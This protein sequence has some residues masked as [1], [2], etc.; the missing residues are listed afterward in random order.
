MHPHVENPLFERLDGNVVLFYQ[1]DADIP[2][3]RHID[4][5]LVFYVKRRKQIQ[6]AFF[7]R[8]A[9]KIRQQTH[10]AETRGISFVAFEPPFDKTSHRRRVPRKN[11]HA[12]GGNIVCRPI[13]N[14]RQKFLRHC[15][16]CVQ[17]LYV[18]Q[19]AAVQIVFLQIKMRRLRKKKTCLPASVKFL[20]QRL[21]HG[22]AHSQNPFRRNGG[23]KP[24]IKNLQFFIAVFFESVKQRHNRLLF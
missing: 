24:R 5:I 20:C 2:S 19:K 6:V 22:T 14:K 1:R 18:A 12:R 3:R 9:E 15:N 7:K 16:R 13:V 21:Y 10:N 23:S 8:L 4:I 11:F 17:I